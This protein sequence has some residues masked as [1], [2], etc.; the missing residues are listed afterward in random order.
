MIRGQVADTR[1]HAEPVV[2]R[3]DLEHA[4]AAA[5]PICDDIT[6]TWVAW[7]LRYQRVAFPDPR[8]RGGAALDGEVIVAHG[9]LPGMEP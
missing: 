6:A 9:A 2:I 1:V 7:E 4:P 8:G 5:T 3:F